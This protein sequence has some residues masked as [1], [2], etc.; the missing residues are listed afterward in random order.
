[1]GKMTVLKIAGNKSSN[2]IYKLRIELRLLTT[3][4]FLLLIM[5]HPSSTHNFSFSINLIQVIFQ[6]IPPPIFIM[7]MSNSI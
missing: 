6:Y 5:L 1:M 4:L 3:R 2:T 7:I